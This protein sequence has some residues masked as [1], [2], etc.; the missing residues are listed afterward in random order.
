M[1]NVQRLASP[2]TSVQC[3]IN[4]HTSQRLGSSCGRLLCILLAAFL[5]LF[6]QRIGYAEQFRLT[7]AH[8]NDTHS[9]LLPV[10]IELSCNGEQTTMS[11]G[12]VTRL[13]AKL[14]Q[15]RSTNPH[16]L[17]LHAGDLF[18][19]TVFF[20]CYQGTADAA[21]LNALGLDGA[22]P[23]NHEFDKGSEVLV[24][25]ARQASFPLLA[26]NIDAHRIPSLQEKITPYLVKQFG[27]EKVGVIGLANPDTPFLSLPDPAIVFTN[28]A[29]AARREIA[30]LTRQ[31]INKIIVLSHC[32]FEQDLQLARQVDGIDIIIGGHTHTLLGPFAA[33]GLEPQGHY[34]YVVKT[35]TAETVLV[36]Q[37]WEWAK[38][39]G[40]LNVVF[41][42]QGRIVSFQGQPVL[43]AAALSMPEKDLSNLTQ[44]KA[45]AGFY[46]CLQQHS[47]SVDFLEEDPHEKSILATYTAPV[48]HLYQT[49]LAR[50]PKTL[51]HRRCPDPLSG[52]H[53]E[54]APLIAEALLWKVRQ[55]GVNVHCS[56]INAGS[57]SS[58][59]SAGTLSYGRVYD[60][61]PF[62]N[63]LVLLSITGAELRSA[64]T[65]GVMRSYG[66]R[67]RGGMFPYGAGIHVT[68]Q[69]HRGKVVGVGHIAVQQPDGG[70][71]PLRENET[72]QVALN[73]Y[74]ARGGDGYHV[75]ARCRGQRRA[76]GIVDADAFIEYARSLGVLR[77]PMTQSIS[78]TYED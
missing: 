65:H 71:M 23:G 35:G 70:W 7:I 69:V 32:G 20:T 24:N 38:M 54:V 33:L 66:K 42:E 43:L 75:F 37:A 60:L 22:C 11:V 59:L 72:Y 40:V 39:L 31:G 25:F 63:A 77:K 6:P 76:T 46:D 50:I 10:S 56:L 41:N 48:E 45:P 14:K 9:H 34:P 61:L 36:V 58:S 3:T 1:V 55:T 19:G 4:V 12:G 51:L 13:A 26:A 28:P 47:S 74:M 21:L 44:A 18:Q 68:L 73:E 29:V 52:A 27:E 15:V 16:V 17:F 62:T 30:N 67:S 78:F 64:I 5:L 2:L 8:V 49:T 57:V 53:S